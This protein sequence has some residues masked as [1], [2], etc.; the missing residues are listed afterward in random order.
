MRLFNEID[1]A[2]TGKLTR[3]QFVPFIRQLASSVLKN[4]TITK[5]QAE[6]MFTALDDDKSEAIEKKEIVKFKQ[7]ME[8]NKQKQKD[9]SDDT[10]D[11]DDVEGHFVNILY[12]KTSKASEDY[13]AFDEKYMKEEEKETMEPFFKGL[14]FH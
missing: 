7:R 10:E 8:E 12:D 5:E 1:H 6:L 2:K 3:Q 11:S 14:K 4:N 9:G 13:K